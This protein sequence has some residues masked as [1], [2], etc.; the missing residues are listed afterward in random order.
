MGMFPYEMNEVDIG[1][2]KSQAYNIIAPRST[3]STVVMFQRR[4]D[5]WYMIGSL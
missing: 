2:R 1:L 4:G 3:I 5:S